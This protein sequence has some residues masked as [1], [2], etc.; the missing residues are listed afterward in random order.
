MVKLFRRNK[1]KRITLF[2]FQQIDGINASPVDDV[3]KLVFTTC[4]IFG[5]TEHQLDSMKVEKAAKYFR[6]VQDIFAQPFEPLPAKKIG[7]YKITYDPS[8]LTFGQY[9]E[10][11]FFLQGTPL[12]NA[13]YIL[14]TLASPDAAT[15]RQ[16]A[17]YF[18]NQ[19]ITEVTGTLTAF[20]ERFAKFNAE[21]KSLFGLDS[22]VAGEGAQG[23]Q[24]NRRY[25]WIYCASQVAEYER[26]KQEE[27]FALPVRQALN[28]LAYLKAKAKY[29]AEQLKK[30]KTNG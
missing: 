21:Y 27:A 13:H 4:A 29:E 20:M 5:M 23:D 10:L 12:K 9:V 19:P 2:R 25:G 28:G 1:W 30:Q 26:I 15:H 11:M 14:A 24:F 18:L 7:R 17:E 22:E 3:D 16:R 8:A 6:K